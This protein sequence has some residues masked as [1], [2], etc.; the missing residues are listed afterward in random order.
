MLLQTCKPILTLEDN[1]KMYVGQRRHENAMLQTGRSR[2][3]PDE[4]NF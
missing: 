1:I 3:I 2:V 4:V